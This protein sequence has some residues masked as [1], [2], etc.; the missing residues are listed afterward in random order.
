MKRTAYTVIVLILALIVL[1][2]VYFALLGDS[3]PPELPAPGR[4]A[5]LP[6]GARVNL[7][8]RGQGPA[9]VLVHGLPG[10]GY[11]WRPLPERL[12]A[13][14]ARVV[15]YDRVGYGHSSRREPGDPFTCEQ[16]ASELLELLELLDLS[17]AT[18]VG[19]SYGGGVVLRAALR[20]PGRIGRLVAIGSVGPAF[21]G[22]PADVMTRMFLSK[23][24]RSWLSKV[25]PLSEAIIAGESRAQAFSGQAMPSWW[26]PQLR[27]SL[28]LPGTVETWLAEEDQF[29]IDGLDPAPL[30]IPLLVI[31]GTD[32]RYVP[33]AVAEDLAERARPASKLLRVEGGSHMLPITH[34]DLLAQQIL[35][36]AR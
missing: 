10:L 7:L 29:A 11:D 34:A 2:P 35:E 13:Q 19:W 27:A 21:E 26:V 25:P 32:D 9:I 22:E 4:R 12:A 23:R 14:G 1:P 17:D 33:M 15:A 3:H 31:Q 8:E 30:E 24:V 5:Q 20:Q 16:N 18:L 28:A 6:G 36:F